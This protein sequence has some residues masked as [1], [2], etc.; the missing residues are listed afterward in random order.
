MAVAAQKSAILLAACHV[1]GR[2][3]SGPPVTHN[4]KPLDGARLLWAI[5]G[6]ESDFGRLRTHARFERGYAPGGFYYERSAEL[7]RAYAEFNSLA[8][9]S[10]GSFQILYITARELGFN[11]HPLELRNDDTCARYASQ[12]I[13]TRFIG[14]Q[15]C[16]TVASI[17]D[18][19]NTGNARD[20]N[21]PESYIA[22]AIKYYEA[23][24]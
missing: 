4:G 21:I 14:R 12:L 20:T 7:Q 3:L 11:Q 23:G 8:A 24:F 22:K 15:R 2:D 18:A 5:A 6:V 1:H 13:G 19:Y 9:S 10:F 17:L 16:R